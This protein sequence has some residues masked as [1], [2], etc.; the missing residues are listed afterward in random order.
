MSLS[1]SRC[2]KANLVGFHGR[3]FGP[4]S[5]GT[6]K[7]RT[8]ETARAIQIPAGSALLD[9]DLIVPEK[10]DGLVIFAHGSGSSRRSPRN[11]LVAELLRKTGLGTLLFD[12]LTPEEGVDDA[13]RGHLRFN[14]GLLT[15]RLVCAA[16]WAA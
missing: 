12:L 6:D 8:G 14:I 13:T 5:A 3:N 15:Q 16:H 11:Q 4:M 2:W 7:L 10:A 1:E 9:G